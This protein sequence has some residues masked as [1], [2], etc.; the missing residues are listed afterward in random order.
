MQA[1]KGLFDEV[2]FSSSILSNLNNKEKICDNKEEKK[3]KRL[4]TI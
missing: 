3:T 1:N 2:L 4:N